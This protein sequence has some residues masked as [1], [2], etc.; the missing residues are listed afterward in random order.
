[1]KTNDYKQIDKLDN[2][3]ELVNSEFSEIEKF[4]ANISI[5]HNKIYIAVENVYGDLAAEGLGETLEVA[6]S[7]VLKN[8]FFKVG[9]N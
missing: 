8:S 9:D 4:K 1:M 6:V 5:L 7:N 3:V 2:Y